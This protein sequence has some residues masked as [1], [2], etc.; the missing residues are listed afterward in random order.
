MSEV[1]IIIPAYNEESNIENVISELKSLQCT[2][3]IVVINDGSRDSTGLAAKRAG[4]D[5]ITHPFN[6]G[7]GG[8]L[9]TGFKYA[10]IKGYKYVV[11]FDGDG[12]HSA[13][14]I[15]AII[16]TLKN[17]NF[18]GVIGSRF[19]ANKKLY[20]NPL[21]IFAIKLFRFII[22]AATGAKI[23]DPTSGLQGLDKSTF[24]Y[25]SRMGNF[26]SDYPDADIIIKMLQKGYKFSEI[27]VEIGVREN[28]TSMHSGIIKQA[29]Y[30][31][32]I[33]LSILIVFLKKERDGGLLSIE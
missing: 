1:L 14:D 8:A 28:G 10:V 25:Y 7:Y 33:S 31:L 24:T 23:T 22:S 9:Q 29:F 11:Q 18:N 19:L 2:H 13:K 12:Q 20:N 16:G 5:V 3:D 15:E 17:S 21:K 32:K 27:P 4:A 6:L 30:M 26:P